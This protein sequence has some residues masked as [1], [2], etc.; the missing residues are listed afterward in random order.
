MSYAFSF[1][2]PTDTWNQ[3]ALNSPLPCSYG[4]HCTRDNCYGV[5]PG[6]EGIKRK[7][8]PGRTVQDREGR[9]VKQNPCVRLVGK[10]KEDVPGYYRRRTAKMSWPAWCAQEGIAV[11]QPMAIPDPKGLITL[12]LPYWTPPSYNSPIFSKNTPIE[13]VF[14]H[15]SLHNSE[16]T[17]YVLMNYLAIVENMPTPAHR[18]A[19]YMSTLSLSNRFPSNHPYQPSLRTADTILAS[20]LFHLRLAENKERIDAVGERIYARAKTYLAEIEP[21]AKANNAWVEG[22]TPGKVTGI[23]LEYLGTDVTEAEAEAHRLLT[24][25]TAFEEIVADCLITYKEFT[26]K[27]KNEKNAHDSGC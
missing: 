20:R 2:K 9:T 4:I 17:Q 24:Q 23:I 8:F 25:P 13:Q 12:I 10:N 15:M 19:L 27:E 21:A 7:Y 11:P 22:F 16:A 5:H 3:K 26:E 1:G 6:E 14:E 18:D